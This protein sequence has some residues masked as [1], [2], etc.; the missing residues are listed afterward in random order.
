MR[1]CIH[2]QNNRSPQYIILAVPSQT[3][4]IQPQHKFK[5]SARLWP[6][7]L[8]TTSAEIF[9]QVATS[10]TYNYNHHPTTICRKYDDDDDDDG[11]G[12]GDAGR[13]VHFEYGSCSANFTTVLW[14]HWE[15]VAE[16]TKRLL[17]TYILCVFCVFHIGPRTMHTVLVTP[18]NAQREMQYTTIQWTWHV[19]YSMGTFNTNTTAQAE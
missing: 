2:Q 4:Q 12:D 19:Q 10:Y 6:I 13:G 14:A 15:P 1:A 16:Q 17:T 11:D 5:P 7:F 8:E 9:A 18:N 3:I